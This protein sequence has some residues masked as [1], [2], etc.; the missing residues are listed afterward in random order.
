MTSFHARTKKK[1]ATKWEKNKRTQKLWQ[2]SSG[3][4]F[5]FNCLFYIV[6]LLF[7]FFSPFYI[8][9]FN[10]SPRFAIN[11]LI[12]VDR[13]KEEGWCTV[14]SKFKCVVTL[15]I[16]STPTVQFRTIWRI[17]EWRDEKTIE[18]SFALDEHIPSHNVS[19]EWMLQWVFTHFSITAVDVESAKKCKMRKRK[20]LPFDIV[21]RSH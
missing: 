10:I 19:Y 14:Y 9:Y 8:K 21:N 12:P 18:S 11:L 20:K 13:F 15:I 17:E 1:T 4:R 6:V 2:H 16:V 7:C 3:W 5:V